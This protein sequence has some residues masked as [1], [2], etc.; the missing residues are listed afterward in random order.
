M[1]NLI[2]PFQAN[3]FILKSMPIYSLVF[4][5]IA[6]G[7]TMLWECY[8][9]F[10]NG[11]IANYYINPRY[12]FHY[13]YFDWVKPWV[14]DGMY[15]HFAV[16]AVLAFLIMA[17]CLYRLS[18]ILFFFGF[19]FVFLLEQAR[20]LNHLYLVC[21]L[22]FL[23]IFLPA[24]RYLSV[25]TKI[26]PE[27]KTAFIE[28]W[29]VNL[30]RFQFAVV[31]CYGGLAKINSDW[32]VG[33]P[34]GQWLAKKTTFP[35]IGQWFDQHWMV[36]AMSH[37]GMWLD[38]LIAPLLLF[39]KTRFVAFLSITTFHFMNDRLFTIGIFPWFMVMATTIFLPAHWPAGLLKAARSSNLRLLA[40]AGAGL[41]FSGIA[42]YMHR[43]KDIMPLTVG[44]IA[45]TVMVYLWMTSHMGYRAHSE[46][47]ADTAKGQ[48]AYFSPFLKYGL[49]AWALVM[50]LLPLRHFFIPG[51]VNWTE[52]GHRWAWHMKLR[53]KDAEAEFFATNT[54]TGKTIDIN[55]RGYLTSWQYRKMAN[56][57]YMIH[58]F[59]GYLGNLLKQRSGNEYKITVKSTVSLNSRK[60]QPMIDPNVDLTK[61][62]YRWWQHNDW[63]LHL[64]EAL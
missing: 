34:M 63:I 62:K 4:F 53:D 27:I 60:E 26:W 22:S 33:K 41:A 18:T 19:T 55:A 6:F 25:D 56:R 50:L 45:G 29:A 32:L 28:A 42:M 10:S 36:L 7:A 57:P 12:N 2:K 20:Y 37:A 17:G 47:A 46:G 3:Q 31:Y 13:Q 1:S 15:I 9:Y 16:L 64:D 51:H 11:W 52:E 43:H 24:H 35:I 23:M 61:E 54:A 30:L 58:Q 48:S 38:L 49:I 8:R 21:L 14:G 44:F 39:R 40:F 59:A 5:R